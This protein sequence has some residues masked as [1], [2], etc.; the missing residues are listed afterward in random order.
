MQDNQIDVTA[1]GTLAVDYFALVPSIP[2]ADEKIM[3]EGYEV[4]PGGVA[5]NVMTQLARLGVSTGWFGKIGDDEAGKIVL[6]DLAKEGVDKS[7]VEVIKG[8]HTMFTW[9][10][11]NKNGGRSITMFP[12]VLIKL[13]AEDVESKHREYITSSRVLHTEACLLPLKPV[14]RAM[15]IAKQS[16]VKIVFNLDVTPTYFVKEANLAT[17]IE[18]KR[19][20]ELADVLIPCKNAAKELIGSD[21]FIKDG[22][23]LLD[24]GSNVVAIT[25]GEKGCIV[26]DHKDTYVGHGYRVKVV[27]TTGAGDAF[28]GGFIYSVLKGLSLKHAGA[29]AN[30]CG[31][32]CCTKVGARSSGTL[33]EVERLIQN[34]R[35]EE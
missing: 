26:F 23:K 29:F 32:L 10:L 30:A 9:I 33:R 35:T 3:S 14:V 1:I 27:D 24:Y 15:E 11:V 18:M 2:A 13:T 16:G 4:H 31:A 7:H 19:A 34:E 21:D 28:H 22:K 12:N 5:G 6:E 20:L 17:E 8:E 25:L